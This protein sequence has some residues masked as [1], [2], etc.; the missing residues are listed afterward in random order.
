MPLINRPPA[1]EHCFEVKVGSAGALL[2]RFLEVSGLSIEY[3]V[4]PYEEGGRNDFVYQ[5]R[6]RLKQS[7]LTLKSGVTSQTVLLD[8]VLQR[9]P[10]DQ[11]QD[12]QVIFKTADDK[13]LRSF[14]F[15]E[16]VPIRWTGPNASISANAVA[17]ESLEIVHRGLTA[18]PAGRA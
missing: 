16:A 17:T 3:A 5:H 11:P 1:L 4:H 15:K 6:G 13:V 9:P 14:G 10:F 8:W 2:G 12:L 7:N 18:G